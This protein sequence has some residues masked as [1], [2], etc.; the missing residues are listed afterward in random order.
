MASR[1]CWSCGIHSHMTT[2]GPPA[3]SKNKRSWWRP[4]KC[5]SC[6]ALSIAQVR[7]F[8]VLSMG[9]K[10]EAETPQEASDNWPETISEWHPQQS[11]GRR[12]DDVPEHIA[13]AASEAYACYQIRSYRAAILMARSVVE[14]TAK[15]QGITKGS[16]YEKIDKLKENEVISKGAA[17]TA[18]EIRFMGNDMAHGDFVDPVEEAECDDLLNF[19]SV[20]LD[21]VYQTPAKLSRHRQARERRH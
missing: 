9:Q 13:D 20:L 6:G 10:R 19:M 3:L 4:Y 11:L 21:E 2:A 18:H 1:D 5:D 14:A 15:D 8:I 17:E 12:F 16:L 7:Q